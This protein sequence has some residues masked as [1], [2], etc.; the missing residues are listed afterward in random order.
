MNACPCGSGLDYD[1]CCGAII[2]GQRQAAT[3]LELMRSR[4]TA[5]ARQEIDYL[6]TSML[7]ETRDTFDPDSARQ[8]SEQSEWRGFDVVR[9]EAGGPDDDTGIVEFI[10]HYSIQG[11]E[12]PHHEVSQFRRV[13]GTWYFVDGKEV[14]VPDRRESPKVGRNDPCPCGSGEKYKKCC[15]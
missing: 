6:G 3:A 4:Y 7:P 14:S 5:F 1:A 8:W 12:V 13:G 9:T 11:T 2:S 10:A 15:A